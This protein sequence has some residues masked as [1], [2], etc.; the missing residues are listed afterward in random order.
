MI[1]EVGKFNLVLYHDV[2]LLYLTIEAIWMT[3]LPALIKKVNLGPRRKL[4][5]MYQLS[6]IFYVHSKVFC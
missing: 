4:Y 6:D 5:S 3:K 2:T 1:V